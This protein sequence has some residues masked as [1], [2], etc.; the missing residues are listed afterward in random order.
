MT[1]ACFYTWMTVKLLKILFIL[2]IYLLYGMIF[3]YFTICHVNSIS[4]LDLVWIFTAL[5]TSSSVKLT[6]LHSEWPK[7]Q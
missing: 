5:L 1:E 2:F 6:L 4:L 7:P 3:D